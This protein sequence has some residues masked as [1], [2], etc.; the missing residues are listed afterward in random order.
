[1][2][3]FLFGAVAAGLLTLSGAA[4]ASTYAITADHLATSSYTTVLG[5]T[6]DGNPFGLNVYESPDILTV[7]IDGGPSQDLL[8]FCV[9][10]F[11]YFNSG[12]P[13]VTYFSSPVA[14]N[15][16]SPTSGGGVP[17]S[18]LISGEI[19]YL[20][21][22]GGVTSDAERLAGIQGAI[23][24]IEYPSLTLSGGSS[25]VTYYTGLAGAW[26][27]AHPGYSGYAP[28]IY[29]LD[30]AT[31]GFGTTQGFVI[32]GGVPEPAIWAFLISGLALAGA[33]LRR[34]RQL[35]LAA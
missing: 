30:G 9:D 19:G 20:A 34:A 14:A 23:W 10:I 28:G 27:A 21:N 29:P 8:V 15:S 18:S 12:T 25:F 16:D 22:L 1:M 6:V 13:P 31:G 17:L 7:S 26:G 32:G 5:G 11:H 35:A 4:S 24:Q 2:R 33:M 3:K